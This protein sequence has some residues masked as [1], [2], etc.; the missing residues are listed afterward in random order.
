MRFQHKKNNQQNRSA[1]IWATRY[2]ASAFLFFTLLILLNSC[3]SDHLLGLKFMPR[4][5]L[6]EYSDGYESA[7]WKLAKDKSNKE[8]KTTLRLAEFYKKDINSICEDLDTATIQKLR[9][10][11]L[12]ADFGEYDYVLLSIWFGC[13][14]NMIE[15]AQ[16]SQLVDT[17]SKIMANPKKI[18][19]VL[20]SQT[21]NFDL[22]DYFL[23]GYDYHYQSYLIPVEE[24]GNACAI[25]QKEFIKELSPDFYGE[26][27]CLVGNYNMFLLNGKGE[28]L[29]IVDFE[30]ANYRDAGE[31]MQIKD[32]DGLQSELINLVK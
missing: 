8:N 4:T 12:K 6:F 14:Y 28:L 29:K 2:L 9:V 11:N 31:K 16:Y 21:Y 15:V 23:K 3:S 7:E 27:K 1:L 17:L 18:A 24:Y 13:S 10:A 19:F 25:K 20:T 5:Y 30:I 26:K 32:F 22:I